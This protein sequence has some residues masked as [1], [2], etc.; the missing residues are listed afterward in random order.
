MPYDMHNPKENDLKLRLIRLNYAA[1]LLQFYINAGYSREQSLFKASNHSD[2]DIEAIKLYVPKYERENREL[3]D[4]QIYKNAA[5][6]KTSISKLAKMNKIDRSTAARILSKMHNYNMLFYANR[7]NFR[8]KEFD[9]S[10]MTKA[11]DWSGCP[12]PEIKAGANV[13]PAELERIRAAKNA[14]IN[15]LKAEIEALKD[16]YSRYT[17]PKISFWRK[18]RR[19]IRINV[20]KYTHEHG[21][22]A[23]NCAARAQFHLNY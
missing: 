12:I 2:I 16:K 23:P 15:A 19:Y 22:R 20:F 5:I 11:G 10:I 18:M 7:P 21:E 6:G 13:L 17:P 1:S 9:R 4:Y 8:K 3:R 14:E